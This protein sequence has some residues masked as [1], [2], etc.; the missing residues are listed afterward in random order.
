M[1]GCKDQSLS[2]GFPA[3][4][5]QSGGICLCC[6]QERRRNPSSE[7][8]S[9]HTAGQR[10]EEPSE[11]QVQGPLFKAGNRKGIRMEERSRGGG[12][13]VFF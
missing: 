8:C 5:R 10:G 3:P 1:Y 4:G 13:L 11:Q 6:R 2:A 12:G 7:Q 9:A